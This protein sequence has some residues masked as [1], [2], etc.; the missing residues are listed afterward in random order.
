MPLVPDAMSAKL[1]A[2][3]SRAG[4]TCLKSMLEHAGVLTY[5]CLGALCPEEMD[6]LCGRVRAAGFG[7]GHSRGL[8]ELWGQAC[9][10][11]G[12][13]PPDRLDEA[14]ALPSSLSPML[15]FRI[16]RRGLGQLE[17]IL[18][19]CGVRS[20]ACLGRLNKEEREELAGAIGAAGFDAGWAIQEIMG[21]VV[22]GSPGPLPTA[23]PPS[24]F[25][26]PGR[27]L[28]RPGLRQTRAGTA[29]AAAGSA[30]VPADSHRMSSGRRAKEE[31]DD[32]TSVEA[33]AASAERPA[34][35]ARVEAGSVLAPGVALPSP[36]L[37]GSVKADPCA[38]KVKDEPEAESF[39]VKD[40]PGPEGY[41]V[42]DERR[43]PDNSASTLFSL[44]D[45]KNVRVS[46]DSVD[47]VLRH[48]KVA[49]AEIIR[50]KDRGTGKM[51][52][53]RIPTAVLALLRLRASCTGK[54]V[55]EVRLARVAMD[56]MEEQGY[57]P[58]RAFASLSPRSLL[59]P[60]SAV[61]VMGAG[62]IGTVFKEEQT[63]VVVKV[64]LED[65]AEK[66]YEIFCAFA[67]AGLAARPI[68]LH[69]P[70]VVPGGSLYC[71]RMEAIK[72]TLQ[73][74]LH[75][76]VPRGPRRGL[77]PPDEAKARRIGQAVVRALQGMWDNGLVHGDLHLENVALRDPESVPLVQLL[78][79]GRSARN[80]KAAQS[81][82]AEALRAGHEYDVFRLLDEIHSDYD[83]LQ[84]Q[85]T[86]EMKD[87]EKELLVL[88]RKSQ[89][90]W[91][92]SSG[93]TTV[94]GLMSHVAANCKADPA[95]EFASQL[96]DARQIAGLRAF[97]ADEPRA[98][99]QAEAAYNN[100]L[101][102]V[103][104]YA[105]SKLDL[106]FDGDV[107]LSNRRMRQAVSKRRGLGCKTYFKSNLFW[108]S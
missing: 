43:E 97:V 37:R 81:I 50:Y 101:A 44:V 87:C 66:E 25:F 69:G 93:K 68:S 36:V 47:D 22:T 71:I 99:A 35:R 67:D 11:A 92:L 91:V 17:P 77:N 15:Y 73:G 86:Q 52:E 24:F 98:L 20:V 4:L 9:A 7:I 51:Q 31:P 39:T 16:A 80:I 83:E 105:C 94:Q 76:R 60:A 96:H 18:A 34:K 40:E 95:S 8:R 56:V 108:G 21:A 90:A 100:I 85:T 12:L 19:H 89:H 27:A 78:D 61:R 74:V 42:K 30:L 1:A 3:V 75:S 57:D 13:Q 28:D 107:S 45:P 79:F 49:P 63:G 58:V 84:E 59:C 82:S 41:K 26:S 70:K 103:V 10:V 104:Q 38:S 88:R 6:E 29:S 62:F 32:D 64:M 2:H 5:A 54:P 65:F 14:S 53:A 23:I 48:L 102:V 46:R 33:P 106:T 72:H 55:S